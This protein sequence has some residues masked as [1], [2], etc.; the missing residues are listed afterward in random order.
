[1]KKESVILAVV[2]AFLVGFVAGAVVGIVWKSRREAGRTAMVQPPPLAPPGAPAAPTA[3]GGP[4]APS[5]QGPSQEEMAG[6]IQALKDIV[7]KDPKNLSAW[8]ELG[9][10]YFDSDQPK[11]AIEAYSKYLAVKPDNA[12][13]RTDLGIMYRKLGDTD[14]ALK[15]FRQAA[16]SDSKH[17]NSRYN[18]GIVLL[19]D[20]QDIKGA[21]AAWKEYLKVDPDSERAQRIKSQIEKMEKMAK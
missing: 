3:P 5:P 10:L 8:V 9:N 18:I 19:H 14:R 20:K 15:E 4:M 11:E 12:D 13:V 21:V 6:K 16:Q 2:V 7:N 17:A 1:M